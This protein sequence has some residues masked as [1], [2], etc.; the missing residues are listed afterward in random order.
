MPFATNLPRR[1]RPRGL[2]DV[3]EAASGLGTWIVD[4]FWGLSPAIISGQPQPYGQ[5]SVQT[6]LPRTPMPR[7]QNLHMGPVIPGGTWPTLRR[8]NNQPV[9]RTP[10]ERPGAIQMSLPPGAG[11]GPASEVVP[12]DLAGLGYIPM[13]VAHRPAYLL[14]PTGLQGYGTHASTASG[15][16]MDP[17]YLKRAPNMGNLPGYYARQHNGRHVPYGNLPGYYARQR[18]GARIPYG[19]LPPFY[20]RRHDGRYTPYG[21]SGCGFGDFVYKPVTAGAQQ[22]VV[23]GAEQEAYGGLG[24]YVQ[25]P[26]SGYGQVP[27]MGWGALAVAAGVGWWLFG[28][29]TR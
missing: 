12:H 26:Y 17:A 18:D 8:M 7:L 11:P 5:T 6:L 3:A 25:L 29:R 22:E 23:P 1:D 4:D 9:F 19:N 24:D 28:R 15:D 16:P 10:V 13:G 21:G 27:A 20:N 2:G 14:E